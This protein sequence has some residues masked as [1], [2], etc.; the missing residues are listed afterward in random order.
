MTPK[1]PPC[2]GNHSCA[3]TSHQTATRDPLKGYHELQEFM[4]THVRRK[5]SVPDVLVRHALSLADMYGDSWLQIQFLKWLA[6]ARPHQLEWA[7]L[8]IR[9]ATEKARKRSPWTEEYIKLLLEGWP[10]ILAFEHITEWARLHPGAVSKAILSVVKEG[11]IRGESVP[12]ELM[13][14]LVSSAP[15]FGG[16]APAAVAHLLAELY[17]QDDEWG[18]RISSWLHLPSTRDSRVEIMDVLLDKWPHLLH[19]QESRAYVM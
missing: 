9:W 4:R 17:P 6:E 14:T 13:D 19:N 2:R 12:Y 1:R 11:R 16:G 5:Q 15:R 18:H 7:Q 10:E 8:P 3:R